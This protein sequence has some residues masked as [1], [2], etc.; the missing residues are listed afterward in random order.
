[1]HRVKVGAVEDASVISGHT[2]LRVDDL[3]DRLAW[4]PARTGGSA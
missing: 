4:V 2:G 1:M 3:R